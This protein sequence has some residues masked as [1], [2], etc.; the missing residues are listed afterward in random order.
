VLKLTRQA[1][2]RPILFTN[3]LTKTYVSVDPSQLREFITSKLKA[4][5]EEELDVPLVLFDDVLDHVL[6]IDRIFRQN[7]GKPTNSLL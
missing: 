1:L 3:W 4:F 7:Q 2:V 5:C 6:R